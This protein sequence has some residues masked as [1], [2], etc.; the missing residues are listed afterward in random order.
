MLKGI[1][2]SEHQGI[3]DWGAAKQDISFAMLRAGYG[4][5]N[6]DKQFV[7]NISECNRLGIPCGVYWF[8]YALTAEDAAREGQYCLAAIEPYRVEYPLAFDLEYDTVERAKRNGVAITKELASAMVNAFCSTVE[9]AQYYAMNYANPDFLS[10]YFDTAVAARFDLWLASWPANVSN[11]DTPPRKC[12]VWQYGGRPIKGMTGNI[13]AN[14][15]YKD[16]AKMIRDYGLNHLASPITP[17][18]L[19]PIVSNLDTAVAEIVAAGGADVIMGIAEM[20][21][22]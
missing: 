13:D 6:I 19:P 18:P 12:G 17:E 14:V 11:L 5:N 2:V 22:N 10:R 4:R 20:L 8:S 3:I 7:R 15:S 9:A 21:K 1:D 16:Y